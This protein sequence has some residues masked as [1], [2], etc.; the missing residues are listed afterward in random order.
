MLADLHVFVPKETIEYPIPHCYS[1][2]SAMLPVLTCS[3]SS[4]PLI[5]IFITSS[6]HFVSI[7][8]T[9]AA[10]VMSQYVD[11]LTLVV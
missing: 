11:R 8:V 2:W 6:L 3:V 7:V 5:C 4:C 10:I 1:T 9:V